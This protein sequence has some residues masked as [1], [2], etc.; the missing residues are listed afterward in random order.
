MLLVD[1]RD[2]YDIHQLDPCLLSGVYNV[3]PTGGTP[4]QVYC[5]MTTAG[6]G[7]TVS[8]AIPS[9]I[10]TSLGL[11]SSCAVNPEH[12]PCNTHDLF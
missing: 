11:A 3:T 5:D 12:S 10:V 9:S 1:A 4:I 2:C 6:G 8:I 7:W